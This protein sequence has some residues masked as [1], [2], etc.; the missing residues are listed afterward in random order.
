MPIASPWRTLYVDRVTL[1]P[2][3][4][5]AL[6]RRGDGFSLEAA[7]PLASLRLDPRAG[8]ELRGDVG[9]VLS[10]Q[11]GT[12]VADRVYWSN[13]NTKVVSDLPSEAR[14]EPCL[15]GVFAFE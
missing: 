2:G 13:K 12:R 15:W 1:L 11:T 4:R 9:R 3:A 6:A 14:L 10:D 7:V 5:I 8:G